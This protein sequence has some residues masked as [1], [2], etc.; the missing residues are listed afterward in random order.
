VTERILVSGYYGFGNTGDEAILASIAQH[1]GKAGELVVLSAN[2]RHTAL[3]HKVRAI[4]R[5]DL[6]AI[7]RELG[8]AALF[9]SGGGGLLQDATG[10]GSVPYYAGLLKMAQWRRVPTMLLGAGIGP[11]GTSLGQALTRM[12]ASRCR[13]CAVRDDQ[14]ARILQAL[15]VEPARIAVTADTV[16][17]LDP[18]APE[19]V[20]ELLARGG[21]DLGHAP[22][23]GV[24]IRPWPTWFERQFK[25]FSAVLAQVAA[26]EGA[27]V[28]LIPFQ[29][30]HDDRITQELYDCLQFRPHSHAPRVTVL[31]EPMT[32]AETLGVLGRC[33]LVFAMRLHA[34]IMAAASCV[35]FV[36]V[37]YDPKVEHFAAAW[38]MPVVLG[39]EGLEDSRR[40]EDLVGRMWGQREV[41]AGVMRQ[42]LPRQQDLARQNFELARQTAGLTGDLQWV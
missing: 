25:A 28:L 8:R 36:G 6:P 22:A 24:A 2:P 42:L 11:L 20:D 39:V 15:G 33:G 21:V 27:Q 12:A 17:A 31:T 35:P 29:R 16:L 7:A 13:V 32:A 3:E 1:L 14:S 41:T 38:D 18:A 10:P 4:S 40:V 5:L 19:R 34:L 37:A 26:R 23:I 30:P 9:V